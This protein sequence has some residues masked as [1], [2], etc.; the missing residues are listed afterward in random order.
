MGGR[1]NNG[2][3]RGIGQGWNQ[4]SRL[5]ERKLFGCE[6]TWY[7]LCRV[8]SSRPAHSLCSSHISIVMDST[9]T[10]SLTWL[11]LLPRLLQRVLSP[12]RVLIV[13]TISFAPISNR[14]G[15]F[16][17]T[18]SLGFLRLVERP[19]LRGTSELRTWLEG[20]YSEVSGIEAEESR[21]L[22]AVCKWK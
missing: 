21:L 1:G 9:K 19:V 2:G 4:G 7:P 22:C 3:K 8:S 20:D 16:A 5:N 12:P 15:L 6:L 10:L 11:Q 14:I 13:P 18:D 17:Y